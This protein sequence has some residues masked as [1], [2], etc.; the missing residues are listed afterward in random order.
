MSLEMAVVVT[1]CG[2]GL[3][4]NT[5]QVWFLSTVNFQMIRQVVATRKR[6][7]ALRTVVGSKKKH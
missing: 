1:P 5:T 6:L 2:R 3:A 4:T 7:V